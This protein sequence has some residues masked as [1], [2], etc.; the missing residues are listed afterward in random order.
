M[1]A[2][3][4]NAAVAATLTGVSRRSGERDA[5][6]RNQSYYSYTEYTLKDVSP[7][8]AMRPDGRFAYVLNNQ[9]RDVTII[10]TGNATVVDRIGGAGFDIQTLGSASV[11]ML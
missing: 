11:A 5:S 4:L 7:S 6:R 2:L 8:M 10:D 3:L 1:S 9:T